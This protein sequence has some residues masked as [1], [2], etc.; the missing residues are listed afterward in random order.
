MTVELFAFPA[1]SKIHFCVDPLIFQPQS[2][3]EQ[4]R[5][6]E[7]VRII[8]AEVGRRMRGRGRRL[9]RGKRSGRGRQHHEKAQDAVGRNQG[10]NEALHLKRVRFCIKSNLPANWFQ[11]P[12]K[13]AGMT[14]GYTVFFKGTDIQKSWAGLELLMHELFHVDQVRRRGDNEAR[15]ACDYGEG[16]LK[17]GSYM[18][19]PMEAKAYAFVASHRLPDALPAS[20]RTLPKKS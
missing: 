6:G 19:N 17:G 10:Q 3:L 5:E 1:V 7:N 4:Q 12:G 8:E 13:V 18:K 11:S 20:L 16:V 14:F 2:I 9:C 15:F